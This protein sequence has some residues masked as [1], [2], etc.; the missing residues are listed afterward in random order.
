[1]HLA[2]RLVNY[3][4]NC[5]KRQTGDEQPLSAL[6]LD[7][8]MNK[9]NII[10][11]HSHDTGRYVQPYGYQIPTPHIQKLAEEGI[12]FRQAFCAAPTCSPSRAALLTGQSAHNAGMTGLVNRGWTL[13]DYSQHLLH[14]LRA[15]G[16]HT[17][18]GG[19]QHL[20]SDPNTLGFDTVLSPASLKVKDVA[21]GVAEFL[22]NAPSQPFFLDAGFFETHREFPEP[23]PKID[24]RYVRPP[25]TL[26]D[27][28]ETRA[29]MVAYMTMARQLDDGYGIILDALKTAGLAD[30]TLVIA[31]TDHGVAFPGCKGTL[32]DHGMGV[33]LIMRGP[34]HFQGGRVCDAL[35]SQIDIF[36]TLCDLLQIEAPPWLQGKSMMPLLEGKVDEIN[37]AVFAEVSYH[38]AYEPKRAVRTKRYSYIR[39]YVVEQTGHTT[40]VLANCDDSL[41][42]DV[43][44]NNGWDERHIAAEQLYDLVFDPNESNNLVN[45]PAYTT[46]L[47]DMRARLTAW[48]Q[49]TD[50]PLLKGPVPMPPGTV[51]NKI[52]ARS[53]SETAGLFKVTQ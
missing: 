26:P 1:M 7:K 25:A 40:M 30:N 19:L 29:D 23:N 5:Y 4:I 47:E 2:G 37:E 6:R 35:V 15:S 24:P 14:T 21:P 41:S 36:P 3:N 48:M 33:M 52:E 53:P 17:A 51:V 18:L 27:T 32:T 43:W 45:D 28:P 34:G 39:R 16:Y 49:E 44:L 8:M 12:L 31:T 38:A 46:V 13:D 50:D 10:Y 22:Q 11:L 20:A 42:K 9:P